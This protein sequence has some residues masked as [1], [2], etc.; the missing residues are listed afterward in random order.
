MAE[1][2]A[3]SCC[4]LS[5]RHRPEAGQRGG[6]AKGSSGAPSLVSAFEHQPLHLNHSR[7]KVLG[8]SKAEQ[9]VQLPAMVSTRSGRSVE[10]EEEEEEGGL[11]SPEAA[12]KRREAA[13]HGDTAA[14]AVGARAAGARRR[15]AAG[16]RGV[17]LS[18][19]QA[20]LLMGVT[21]VALAL[22][23]IFAPKLVRRRRPAAHAP[24]SRPGRRSLGSTS[25]L[26]ERWRS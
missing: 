10:H 6:A 7:S 2:T 1:R 15:S 19:S 22:P 5:Q 24:R 18:D 25:Q 12:A 11:G 16:G 9:S 8:C 14:T 21:L 20:W 4:Q 3:P 13:K 17:E 26:V 23:E